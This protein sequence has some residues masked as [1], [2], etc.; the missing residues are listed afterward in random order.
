MGRKRVTRIFNLAM[1]TPMLGMAGTW[2]CGIRRIISV[3]A[4]RPQFEF[5]SPPMGG[6]SADKSV[7]KNVE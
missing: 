2:M 4:E 7:V 1:A 3:K 6:L 5:H